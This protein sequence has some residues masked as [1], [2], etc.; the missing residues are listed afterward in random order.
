[1]LKRNQSTYIVILILSF[2]VLV[3]I[4]WMI[5]IAFRP[6]AEVFITPLQVI[7]KHPSLESFRTVFA[8]RDLLRL[9]VNS[10]IISFSVTLICIIFSAMSGYAFSRFSFRGRNIALLYILITQ[11]FPMVLLSIPYFLFSVKIGIYNTYIALILAYTSFS[12][13]FSIMMM[14]DFI[15][16]IPRELDEAA[17]IDG[18]GIMR[19]FFYIILPPSIPGMIATGI[20]T[21]I[22]SWNEYLFAVILTNTINVRPLTIGIGML[23]GE[24][25]TEWNALMSLT[26]L[27][28]AP[29]ILIFLFLQ[30]YFLQ[31]L[32]AGSVK[33]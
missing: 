14:R 11:M 22:L 20:Y 18:C 23:I 19:T 6:N 30:K 33:A 17:I 3:P 28:S 5:S 1:M 27:A 24:Y 32:T 16:T 7:P 8:N 29:L 21:F 9:F 31:G 25:S 4:F 2:A 15:A 10:Y 26:F 12:L 13:P